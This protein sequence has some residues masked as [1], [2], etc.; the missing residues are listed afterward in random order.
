[1]IMRVKAGGTQ[2]WVCLAVYNQGVHDLACQSTHISTAA[3][4]LTFRPLWCWFLFYSE[5]FVCNANTHFL[6]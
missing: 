1:M 4:R 3:G 5:A 2:A 6:I